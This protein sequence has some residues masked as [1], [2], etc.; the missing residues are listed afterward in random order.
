MKGK[1][2]GEMANNGILPVLEAIGRTMRA[3]DSCLL[4]S[5]HWWWDW[6]QPLYP[7]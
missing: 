7:Q 5:N 3:C 1:E 6:E 4:Y 2:K